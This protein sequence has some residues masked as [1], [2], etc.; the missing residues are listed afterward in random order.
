M[1]TTKI[2]ANIA[3]DSDFVLESEK[4]VANGVAGLDG[5]GKVPAAQL[6]PGSSGALSYQGTWNAS[7]NTPTLVSATGTQGEYYVVST[8][9]T[10]NLDGVASWAVG[11]W[12]VYN[13]TAWEKAD[14]TDV[15]ASVHGRTGAV[16]G[17]NDDYTAAQVT[18]T[19]A[20]AI[21]AVTVQ[22]AIDELD[23]EKAASSH[24]HTL[25]NVTDS[26]ALA[27]LDTVGAAQIDAD[28]VTAA[29]LANMAQNT[30]KGRITAS[31]GDPEDLSAAQVRTIINVADGAQANDVDTLLADTT[32]TLT[33]G[34][35]D[36]ANDAGTK[37]SGTWTPAI[38]D[39][40]LQNATVGGSFTLG[41]PT[42]EGII[43]VILRNNGTGGY[44]L[45]TSGWDDVI[46]TYDNVANKVQ[47][48]TLVMDSTGD[49]LLISDSV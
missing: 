23:S 12:A 30:I 4:G 7:T 18:N 40:N 29:K 43:V 45:T 47:I 26:G 9:G 17:A 36:Q 28:A 37:S 46:G 25:A 48:L 42:G 13:G 35:Q 34:Y 10:T 24:T 21:A 39:G 3:E 2:V 15:V 33:V 38:A 22:A 32:D 27:A 1:S 44:T 6:P 11:D 41:V 49:V 8:N 31:T 19:P 16:V 5:S 20:G 14:H